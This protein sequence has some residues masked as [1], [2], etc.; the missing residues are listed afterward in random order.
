[1]SAFSRN[2]S[3]TDDQPAP[4]RRSPD[5]DTASAGRRAHVQALAAGGLGGAIFALFGLPLAWMLGAMTGSTILALMGQGVAVAP[6]VRTPMIA[7]LGVLLGSAFSGSIILGMINWLP[8]ILGLM[9]LALVSTLSAWVVYRRVLGLDPVTAYFASVPGGVSEMSIVGESYGGSAAMI[10]LA[11]V[12]RIIFVVSVVP[13]YFRFVFGLEIPT[14]PPRAVSVLSFPLLEGIILTLCALAG[15]F[16]GRWLRFPAPA[17]TGPMALSMG[18]HV[19]GLSAAPPPAELIAAA[20]IVVGTAIGARFSGYA[21]S[22]L[23][24]VALG[25]LVT[26]TLMIGLAVLFAWAIAPLIGLETASLFIAYA[27]G[28]L[29]EMSLIALS[30]DQDPA[31][32]STLHLVRILTIIAVAAPFFAWRR[33]RP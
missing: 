25:G 26:A 28:G 31:F 6:W 19:A 4:D 12:I 2:N 23:R 1:M 7:V 33:S 20:Q 27:P 29:T 11:H 15:V 3:I 13:L 14:L 30:L 10:G 17:L 22:D 21:L 16:V 24:G 32:V 5:P 9:G 18:V 8:A